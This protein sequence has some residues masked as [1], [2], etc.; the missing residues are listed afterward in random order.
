MIRSVTVNWKLRLSTS[1]LSPPRHPI[2]RSLLNRWR[3]NDNLIWKYTLLI[4][5]FVFSCLM[6][7]PKHLNYQLFALPVCT[8]NR[9]LITQFSVPRKRPN[10]GIDKI[11]QIELKSAK[12]KIPIIV[13]YTR[14]A[15]NR[16]FSNGLETLGFYCKYIFVVIAQHPSM[17][18]GVPG[19]STR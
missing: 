18:L 11:L 10:G 3:W 14:T 17:L 9:N 12:L 1:H 2:N 19:T 8:S 13:S 4:H 7:T 6:P 15:T 5:S 16:S